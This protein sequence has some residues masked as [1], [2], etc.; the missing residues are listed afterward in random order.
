MNKNMR[1]LLGETA[2]TPEE[3]GSSV[4]E[5]L[6]TEL[7]DGFEEVDGRVQPVYTY[8]GDDDDDEA[9][10]ENDNERREYHEDD[11]T[12]HEC[13][14]SKVHCEDYVPDGAPFEA[15]VRVGMAYAFALKRALEE[16][17]LKGPFRVIVGAD[18]EGEY[19]SVTVRYHP[20]RPGQPWLGDDLEGYQDGV[21]A[22]DF[23]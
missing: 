4:P 8:D 12:G 2:R 17:G 23:G 13:L 15:A 18:S 1:N 9:S 21:M 3:F 16:S 7:Q 10:E 5:E 20:V 19:P 22:I 14:W 6:L 11:E